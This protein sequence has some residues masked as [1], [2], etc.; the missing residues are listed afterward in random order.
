MYR[1]AM[2]AGPGFSRVS[3]WGST[4][5]TL[6]A[7]IALITAAALPVLLASLPSTA[8]AQ[9]ATGHRLFPANALRGEVVFGQAPDI[10]LNGQADR[11]A[12]GARIRDTADML[13]LPG[14]M[15]G[16]KATV[17]YTRDINGLIINVWILNNVE[18]A[19]KLWPRTPTEAS[20]WIFNRDT[21]T[22]SK[23]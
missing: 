9:V 23:S 21:Q 8:Q 13:A 17:Q 1:C 5:R 16:Q 19:N 6:A 3:R 10:T 14:S 7:S 4:T 22:W 15:I 20:S 2:P 11:L 18:L 12:P